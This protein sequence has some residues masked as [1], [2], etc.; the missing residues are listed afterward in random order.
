VLITCRGK[1]AEQATVI[2]H[3]FD[4]KYMTE[5][6][7]WDNAQEHKTEHVCLMEYAVVV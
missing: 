6:V 2:K 7:Q 5:L 4:P 3:S 1:V